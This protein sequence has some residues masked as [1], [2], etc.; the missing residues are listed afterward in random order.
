M[1]SPTIG[2]HLLWLIYTIR[3]KNTWR[4]TWKR[5]SKTLIKDWLNQDSSINDT[6]STISKIENQNLT[7]SSP[8]LD[9]VH[10]L[11][12]WPDKLARVGNQVKVDLDRVM[13]RDFLSSKLKQKQCPPARKL[14]S[15]KWLMN[16]SF[17]E[18]KT[19]NRKWRTLE[20]LRKQCLILNSYASDLG[21]NYN[22]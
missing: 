6:S 13:S 17:R 4:K 18:H 2:W 19:S 3:R 20:K 9:R 21:S 1:A 15:L 7:L 5:F 22:N 11:L 8:S 12:S 10:K 14:K 16:R